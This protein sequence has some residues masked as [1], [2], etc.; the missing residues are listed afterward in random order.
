M[1]MSGRRWSARDDGYDGGLD[2]RAAHLALWAEIRRLPAR[3]RATL[4]LRYVGDLTEAQ[5]ARELGV[6]VGSVKTQTH[7]ALRRLRDA[8]PELDLAE[9]LR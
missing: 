3:M 2:D 5:T 9:E 7:R 8:L 1:P 6:S 4:V